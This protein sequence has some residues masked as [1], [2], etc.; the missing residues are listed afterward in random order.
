[1]FFESNRLKSFS[2]INKFVTV[3]LFSVSVPVLSEH[4]VLAPPIVSH[5]LSHL[6]KLFS[7]FILP[8][9]YAN[10]MVTASG[11]PSGTATTIIVTATIK[12]FSSSLSA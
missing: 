6:T 8:T 12:K 2:S 7:S 4:I 10:A 5:A 9:E 11:K 1:M 3:I